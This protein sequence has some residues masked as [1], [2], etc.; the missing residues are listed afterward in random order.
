MRWKSKGRGKEGEG[1]VDKKGE[2]MK[3]IEGAVIGDI[4]EMKEKELWSERE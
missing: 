2:G 3:A 4:R 1:S